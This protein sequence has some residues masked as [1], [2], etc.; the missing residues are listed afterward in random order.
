MDQ[1]FGMLSSSKWKR[2][3]EKFKMDTS[4]HFNDKEHDACLQSVNLFLNSNQL[5]FLDPVVLNKILTIKLPLQ[6]E[7]FRQM[8]NE[9]SKLM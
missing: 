6:R 3:M 4:E 5:V 1:I 9:D 8:R 2:F 7:L